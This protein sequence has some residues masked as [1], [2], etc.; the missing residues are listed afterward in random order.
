MSPNARFQGPKVMQNGR[1]CHIPSLCHTQRQIK[2]IS[3]Q[4]TKWLATIR[5]VNFNKQLVQSAVF[6]K[7]KPSKKEKNG[8]TLHLCSHLLNRKVDVCVVTQ[9]I[10]SAHL[11][12]YARYITML[13]HCV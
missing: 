11:S 4:K 8:L 12:H 3:P 7:S 13:T 2:S 5:Q 1:R 6:T 9:E 10:V